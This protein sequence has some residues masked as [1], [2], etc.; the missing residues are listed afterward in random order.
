MQNRKAWLTVP[1]RQ[2]RYNACK[3]KYLGPARSEHRVNGCKPKTP[4]VGCFMRKILGMS[5]KIPLFILSRENRSRFVAHLE[6]RRQIVGRVRWYVTIHLSHS[7]NLP[8]SKVILLNIRSLGCHM[9]IVIPE[10][11]YRLENR[12]LFQIS[13]LAVKE[14]R[15]MFV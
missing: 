4:A 12:P 9:Q 7:L 13:S 15:F 8:E 6:Q 10:R 3:L 11:Y 5:H 1:S 14:H 2:E